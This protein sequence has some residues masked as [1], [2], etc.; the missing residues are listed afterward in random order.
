MSAHRWEIRTRT[1]IETCALCH[2]E[3]HAGLGEWLYAVP[4]E[5]AFQPVEPACELRP[6]KAPSPQAHL[7][8]PCDPEDGVEVEYC[9]RCGAERFRSDSGESTNCLPVPA[10][11]LF[12]ADRLHLGREPINTT[13]EDGDDFALPF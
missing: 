5:Q 6:P 2:A 1:G 11:R 13:E 3:R 12:P 7:W 9:G 10:E 4:S 8:R